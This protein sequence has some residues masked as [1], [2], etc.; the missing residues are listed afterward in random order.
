MLWETRQLA[1]NE[2][3]FGRYSYHSVTTATALWAAYAYGGPPGI[4]IGTVATTVELT[5][6]GVNWYIDRLSEL[7]GRLEAAMKRGWNPNNFLNH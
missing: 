3:G 5:Y 6:D 7:L 2:I 4:A 1:N